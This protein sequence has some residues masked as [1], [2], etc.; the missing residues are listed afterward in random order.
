MG[1]FKPI[2]TGTKVFEGK[3]QDL[4]GD[5]GNYCPSKGK[6]GSALIGT[7]YGIS[8]IGY[9]QYK[10]KCPTISE[11]KNLT[12]AEAMKIA[13]AQYW[14]QIKGD[15]I[16]SQPLAHLIFD[17]TYGGSS[18]PLHVRQSINKIAGLGT[19]SEYKSF[20]L[21]DN[22]ISW[23]NRLP[24]KKLFDE[25]LRRRLEYVKSNT[26]ATSLTNRLYKLQKMYEDSLGKSAK[27]ANNHILAI[28][29]ITG[30]IGVGLYFVFK[31][32]K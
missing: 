1:S 5:S 22:E 18:G 21:S 25:I 4:A 31:P 11:M 26:Y 29:A 16:K 13:K 30:L 2:W 10:K 27:F 15:Q 9:A 8:A 3:Y 7:K 6:P 23:I 19:V 17:I 24:E 20:T 12:E 14:D 32:K 28:V